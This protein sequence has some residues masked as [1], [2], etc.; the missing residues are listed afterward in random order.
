MSYCGTTDVQ[1]VYSDY[2]TLMT[3]SDSTGTTSPASFMTSADEWLEAEFYAHNMTPPPA[4]P[5]SGTYDYWLR[6]ATANFAVYSA[7]SSILAERAETD[8]VWWNSYMDT[9]Q[10]I[11]DDIRS[12]IKRLSY[13]SAAWKDSISQAVPIANGTIAAPPTSVCHSIGQLGGRYT[14]NIPRLI[15]IEIDGTGTSLSA[16]TFLARL[17]GEAT[18]TIT[19]GEPCDPDGWTSIGW[20]VSVIWTPPLTGSLVIGQ[21]WRIYCTPIGEEVPTSGGAKSGRRQ[22]A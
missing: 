11:V 7:A 2:K 4:D 1:L 12:G 21:K 10:G 3:K 17:A 5:I 14:S 22:W 15:E 20:G 9:A 13:Q 16:H 6:K 19:A 8:E 18:D